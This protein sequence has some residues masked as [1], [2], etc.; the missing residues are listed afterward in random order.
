M[1]DSINPRMLQSEPMQRCRLHQCRGACCLYGV[2]MDEQ[3]W[4][5]ILAAADDIRPWM[6]PD[7]QDEQNWVDERRDSDP[8]APSGKV[9]HSRVLRRAWHYGRTACIFLRRD[10]KCALQAAAAAAGLHPWQYK[11]FYCILHPLDLDEQG[12]I[13]VDETALLLAEAGSCLIPADQPIPLKETFEEELRYFLGDE[14][15]EQL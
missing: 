14:T 11:P 6:P 4:Q 10:Y 1:P 12:R 5:K 9:I 2:W 8:F 7:A 15:Y 3:E 13:T